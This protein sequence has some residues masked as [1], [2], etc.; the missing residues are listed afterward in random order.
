MW[1]HMN[2]TAS[3]KTPATAGNCRL[4]RRVDAQMCAALLDELRCG[5][6]VSDDKELREP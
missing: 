6:E 5:F 4:M 3:H 1:A 2:R